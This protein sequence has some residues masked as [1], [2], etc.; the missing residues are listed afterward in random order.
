MEFNG[1]RLRKLASEMVGALGI[2]KELREIPRED[3]LAD[4]HKTIR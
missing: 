1:D 4:P 2:L 3:F